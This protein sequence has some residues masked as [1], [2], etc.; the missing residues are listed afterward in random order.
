MNKD[1][2]IVILI[3]I[4]FLLVNTAIGTLIFW[5]I[6]SLACNVFDINYNWTIWH[7]LVIEILYEVAKG[8]MGSNN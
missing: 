7:G 5:G 1:N 2:L 3:S 8:I 4:V 6:G